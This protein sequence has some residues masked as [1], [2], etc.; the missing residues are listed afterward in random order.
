MSIIIAKCGYNR[1]T[2][3]AIIY[4]P[5]EYGG[6]NFRRL[7]DQQGIGQVQ[8]FLRH[9]RNKT[10]AG[11]LLRCAVAWAQYCVGTSLPLMENVYDNL[12]HLESK[13]QGGQISGV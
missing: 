11:R 4:G 6:A 9:W 12:P 2:K 1:N 8:L 13:H 3:R 5:L 7:Y 10:T